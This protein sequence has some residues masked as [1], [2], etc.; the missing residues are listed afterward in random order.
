MGTNSGTSTRW[1]FV[2]CAEGK[3]GVPREKNPLK[4]RMR[5][6]SKLTHI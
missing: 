6:N 5:T 4:G 1:L 2:P 3:T